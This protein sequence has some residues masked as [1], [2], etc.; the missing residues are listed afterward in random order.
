MSFLYFFL[1]CLMYLCCLGLRCTT[2]PCL[3]GSACLFSAGLLLVFH[4]HNIVR[5]FY[6]A[7]VLH[8]QVDKSGRL[9]FF[10]FQSGKGGEFVISTTIHTYLPRYHNLSP[11]VS[12]GGWIVSRGTR[13]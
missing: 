11:S 12:G 3:D 6:F 4:S 2:C 10:F 9:F 5:T 8:T 1:S 7:F 13:V